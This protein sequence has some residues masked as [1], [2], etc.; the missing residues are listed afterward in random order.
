MENVVIYNG[1]LYPVS[2]V[3][4]SYDNRAFK[5]GDSIFETVRCYAHYPLHFALHYKRMIKAMLRLHMDIA[6]LPREEMLLDLVVKLLQNKKAFSASR[7]RIELFRSGGGLYTPQQNK[8]NFL[9][10]SSEIPNAKYELNDKGLFVDVYGEM[11]KE[12]NPVSFF[13]NGNSL[14]YILAAIHKQN[15][16]LNDCFLVNQQGKI[17]EAISSNLFWVKKKVIYTPSVYSGCVAGIMRQV[18]IDLIK[19][20]NELNLVELQGASN[21]ELLNADE[22]FLTNAIQGIQW[23]VGYREKRYFNHTAKKIIQSLNTFT[24]E[25]L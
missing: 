19:Q 16:D 10:E 15:K 6:S 17:I 5:Y 11:M 18:I 3:P 23:V 1:H 9:I 14:H 12:Y 7:V 24:F 13:K 21:D 4:I 8:I 25:H 2:K 22:I 20:N